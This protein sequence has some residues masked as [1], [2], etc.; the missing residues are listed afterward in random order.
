MKRNQL[1]VKDI[2]DI[3]PFV[4][5]RDFIAHPEET[6]ANYYFTDATSDLMSKWLDRIVNVHGQTG[7]AMALAG[8]RGVGKSHFLATLGAIMSHPELRSRLSDAHV[9]ASAH[10]LMRRQYPVAH[11]RRGT[12]NTL[13]DELKEALAEL[14]DLT[15]ADLSG[16]LPELL[17]VVSEHGG[18]LPLVLVIDTAFER[19]TR[20]ARDDGPFL[21]EI[22]D[23]AKSLN[24]FLAI[25]LDD[26]IA[27]ADGVNSAIAASFAIDY[28]DQEHL[29]KIVDAHIFPKQ[30]QTLPVIHEIY[31]HFRSILPGFRWS[32]QKF[33]SL[34]P[35]HP[36]VLEVAPF[37]RLFVHD[38]ALLP[39]ASEA[40]S[41]ILSRPSN[42]L[43]ALDEVFDNVEKRL[44][45]IDEMKE[46]FSA[47][48]KLNNDVIGKIPVMQRLQA[49][50]ILKALMLLSLDGD[51]AN[52]V[53]ISAAV[54]IFDEDDSG[55]A[56][57]TV[58]SLLESFVKAMPDDVRRHMEDGRETRYSLRLESKDRLNSALTEALQHV[59]AEV[60]SKI[61]RRLLRE[62][63]SDC[64]ISGESDAERSDSMDCPIIWRG[65]TR[66][67]R[68]YWAVDGQAN[69]QA[70]VSDVIDWEVRIVDPGFQPVNTDTGDSVRVFW[71]PD[72][73][74]KDEVDTLRRFH[75]LLTQNDLYENFSEQVRAAVHSHT[76]AVE[77]IWNRAFLLDAQILAD[78]NQLGFD[79]NARNSQT[80]SELFTSTLAPLFASRYPEH[81]EFSQPLGM[82]EV[83]ILAAD[84]FGGARANLSEVQDLADTFA[85]PLGLV[86]RKGDYL[87]PEKEEE[88]LKL[89][90]PGSVMKIIS[91]IPEPIVSLKTIY[92]ELR[93][94]PWGLGREAQHLVLTALAAQRLIEF[95]TSKGDRISRRSLDLKIIWG[96][97]V[98]IAKPVETAHAGRKLVHWAQLLTGSRAFESTDDNKDR[99]EIRQALQ[100]WLEAWKTTNL[101]GRFAEVPENLLNTKIWRLT[102]MIEKTFGFVAD[103]VRA[104]L[105]DS[106]PLEEA[107]HRIADAF[108]DSEQE[109]ADRSAD[110]KTI[111]GFING[112][113]SQANMRTYLAVAE[114]T[115]DTE[116]ESLRK[117]LS[118]A[119][120]T[121]FAAAGDDHRERVDSLWVQYKTGYTEHFA[122][123]HDRVMRS[124]YLQAKFEELLRSDKWW[125]FKNLSDI[126]VFRDFYRK[127]AARICSE[128]RQ[129]DCGYEAREMLKAH[130]FCVCSFSLEN[131][132]YWESLPDRLSQIVDLGLESYRKSLASNRDI[133][134]PL[135]DKAVKELDDRDASEAA[136]NLLT[137]L[138]TQVEPT[139]FT[140][141]DLNVIGAICRN[142]ASGAGDGAFNPGV[143]EVSP[144]A[145]QWIE[146]SVPEPA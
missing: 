14:L 16:T 56:V 87:V 78:G 107:L 50:M 51:G 130:P 37:V 88:L 114:R 139:S 66:R 40:A 42:S 4:G 52:A 53:E 125:E 124:H 115:N 122:S 98:A 103:T 111:E 105:E 129:L 75:V 10:R 116:I 73:L 113:V 128:L 137:T 123:A 25:A 117:E 41:K 54:L 35:L 84:L 72:E 127:E 96:D 136:A 93:K 74:K 89:P 82:A 36:V 15:A 142:L 38:F 138:Q 65:G 45:E 61:L 83:A 63:F 132:E 119:A 29:Y 26:D 146:D 140:V 47:F 3:R 27:G 110:L 109:F 86:S 77:R 30:P 20:V 106:M 94:A 69:P 17:K 101:L 13:F 80:L 133:I 121:A 58:E 55:K 91:E 60:T 24:V 7:A 97:V 67:G 34:Y 18:D 141:S 62:R 44:R 118:L 11:V 39:F 100:E 22:A 104:T 48:D 32:E 144:G 134:I 120:N 57:K 95:V 131:I 59:P 19:G 126:P 9:S 108:S 5:V 64:T 135:L 90:V 31:E 49:K 71:R 81:P 6:V 1:K 43:I 143:V 76:I 33:S 85:V 145:I 2:V 70:A 68:V 46:A 102:T 28:L 112:V 99:E 21:S 79:E 8:Y 12:R 92:G 23:A